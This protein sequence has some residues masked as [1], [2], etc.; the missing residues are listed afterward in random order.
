MLADVPDLDLLPARFAPRVRAG[1]DAGMELPVLNW[2]IGVAGLPVRWGLVK[3]ATAFTGLGT[4]I[5]LWLDRFGTADGGMLIEVAGQ[6][7]R[8][9]AGGALVA[10]GDERRRALCAGD[11]GGGGDRDADAGRAA[12]RG[13]RSAAGM[14]TLEQIKP[15]FEGLAIETK[16]IGVPEARSRSSGGSWAMGSTAAAR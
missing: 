16:Q 1:F 12:A 4:R 5:A 10:Q 8:R 6:D 3:S 9:D 2:L 14:V 13:A 11:A 7:D 15:W